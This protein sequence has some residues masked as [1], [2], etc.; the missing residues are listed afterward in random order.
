[1][2]KA[3]F[4]VH[5][6]VGLF[7]LVLCDGSRYGRGVK[8]HRNID[9]G[10]PDTIRCRFCRT[11]LKISFSLLELQKSFEGINRRERTVY[12]KKIR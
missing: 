3:T 10:N 4:E 7:Q 1:M 11:Q 6:S 12:L 5:Y 9:T 8:K 2:L